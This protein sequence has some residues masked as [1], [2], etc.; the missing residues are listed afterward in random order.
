MSG[1]VLARPDPER[2]HQLRLERPDLA[3]LRERLD[4][5]L[6]GIKA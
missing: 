4:P 5:V 2:G 3:A 6:E 1:V